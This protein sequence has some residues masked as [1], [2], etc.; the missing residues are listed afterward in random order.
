MAFTK[1]PE[2]AQGSEPE[3]TFERALIEELQAILDRKKQELSLIEY[4]LLPR[5]GVDVAVFMQWQGHSSVRFLELK[6]FVGSRP[7]GVGFGNQRGDGP[8][9]DLLLLKDSELHL[10]DKYIAWVLVDGTIPAGSKR[11]IFF[12]NTQA[13]SAAMR[14]VSRGKQNNFRVKALSSKALTWDDLSAQL[15]TFLE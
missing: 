2:I 13:K 14:T 3:E 9:V 15:A 6:A 12:N 11:F 7:G 5:F 1:E 10:A 4:F 8:Q